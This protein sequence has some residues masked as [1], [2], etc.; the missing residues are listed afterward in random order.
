MKITKNTIPR[1]S[2]I[3][4]SSGNRLA[5]GK[6]SSQI[7]IPKSKCTKTYTAKK[8]RTETTIELECRS[9]SH[10]MDTLREPLSLIYAFN[11]ANNMGTAP[12]PRER[13]KNIRNT[14]N[15]SRDGCL[16]SIKELRKTFITESI[17]PILTNH[18]GELRVGTKA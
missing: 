17:R 11:P 18:H 13:M 8:D 4:L 6:N 3:F 12:K 16:I 1:N 15:S 5:I 7:T 2:R 14:N 9:V 10:G